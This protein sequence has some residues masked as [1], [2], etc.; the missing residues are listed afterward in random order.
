MNRYGFM[1]IS[2]VA[3]SV[4]LA[5]KPENYYKTVELAKAPGI[6]ADVYTHVYCPEFPEEEFY[7]KFACLE[8]ETTV[9]IWSMNWDGYLH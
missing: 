2:Y 4:F 1:E 3:Q 7:I 8:D 5:I 6:Y 9:D